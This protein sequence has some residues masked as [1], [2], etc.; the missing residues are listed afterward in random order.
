MKKYKVLKELPGYQVGD[1]FTF[2]ECTFGREYLIEHGFAKEV[3]DIDLFED[4]L[5]K[6]MVKYSVCKH[7]NSSFGLILGFIDK[8]DNFLNYNNI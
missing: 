1:E 4:E 5:R 6:L 7:N 2:D 3:R 8:E